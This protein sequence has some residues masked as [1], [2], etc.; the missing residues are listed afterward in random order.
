[1]SCSL[2]NLCAFEIELVDSWGDGWNGGEVQIVNTSGAIEA[3]L[4]S[5]FNTGLSMTIPV[6]FC[7]GNTF[8]IV[9]STA[10]SYPEEMGINVLKGGS[11]IASY[12]PS[13]QTGFG[14]VMAT[15]TANCNISCPSLSDVQVLAGKSDA[16]VTFNTN[17][18]TGTFVYTYGPSGFAQATG[19]S[20]IITDSTS[21][22]TFTLTGLASETCYDLYLYSNCGV[23]GTS[24]T[25]GP[26]AVCTQQCDAADQCHYV[27]S[28]YD[29]FG[30]GWNGANI[31]VTING[32]TQSY[33]VSSAQGDSNIVDLYLCA[34]SVISISNAT[35]GTWPSEIYWDLTL[36]SDPT[37][38][39]GVTLGNFA[40]GYIG[41]DTAD[42]AVV[43][44]A[45][46][47]NVQATN[48]GSVSATIT[49]NGPAS[50]TY[51]YE[52]QQSG[53]VV[54]FTGTSS[55]NSVV[56]NGLL[57]N[58]AH[59]F[60]VAQVCGAGDT[61]LAWHIEFTTDTC[62]M[63]SGGTPTASVTNVT[64]TDGQVT[65]DWSSAGNFTGYSINYGNGSSNAGS[66]TTDV[67]TYTANGSYTAVL[68]LYNDCDT[69]VQN[70]TVFMN[71]IG[72]E[73][74]IPLQSL[75]FYPNPTSG[76][77]Q[78]NAKL[79]EA[80]AVEIAIFD[81]MGQLIASESVI[82]TGTELQKRFDLSNRSAGTY[83][84][85]IT[86]PSGLVQQTFVVSH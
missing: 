14:T 21:A 13:A 54:P 48:I 59:F 32:L 63:V 15:F 65:F 23:D 20:T 25:L 39:F 49:W 69:L 46:P 60:K 79:N 33:S 45:M 74:I 57:S 42:C 31:E 58:T 64:A 83:V 70:I 16:T 12:S 41:A 29:S 5:D 76:V 37:Q 81:A 40:T 62:S 84:A 56:L 28:M 2:T 82:T 67:A 86:T 73:E 50:S 30:D 6:S 53:V 11:V 35:A 72:L 51:Y 47:M 68:T 61:S 10:G 18:N 38:T 52:Y 71:G 26:I 80:G 1:L 4:G 24:D 7:A 34:G 66:G 3:T 22:N 78:L 8:N 55:T 43:G 19:S 17:G 77:I 9:V 44:C 75:V 85:R 36:Q 27:L